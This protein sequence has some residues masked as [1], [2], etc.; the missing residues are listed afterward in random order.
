MTEDQKKLEIERLIIMHQ[1][2]TMSGGIH[3]LS[4]QC[5][6]YILQRKLV[7]K[8]FKLPYTQNGCSTGIFYPLSSYFDIRITIKETIGKAERRDTYLNWVMGISNS[9]L[10]ACTSDKPW[11]LDDKVNFIYESIIWNIKHDSNNYNTY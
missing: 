6:K 3:P 7:H 8:F 4:E 2:I 11:T 1:H 5:A 9:F 10:F